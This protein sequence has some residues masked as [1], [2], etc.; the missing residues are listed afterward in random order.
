MSLIRLSRNWLEDFIFCRQSVVRG[1]FR[2]QGH[3]RHTDDGIHGRAYIM[4]H[5]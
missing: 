5:A 1:D 2:A 4:A 3:I